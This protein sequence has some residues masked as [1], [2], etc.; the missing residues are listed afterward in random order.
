M[1]NVETVR[2]AVTVGE[3]EGSKEERTYASYRTLLSL[4]KCADL[5][6]EIH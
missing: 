1:K 5:F 2:L 6:S 4:P 3:S